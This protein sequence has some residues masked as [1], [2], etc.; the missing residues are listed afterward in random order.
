MAEN[1]FMTLSDEN[2]FMDLPEEK[3]LKSEQVQMKYMPTY[4]TAG[5]KDYA[6]I[7]GGVGETALNLA[8]NLVS[9]AI[10]GPT[11]LNAGALQT[12]AN[13]VNPEFYRQ[14][15]QAQEDFLEGRIDLSQLTPDA[16]VNTAA[17]AS[18]AVTE[19][20]R[21]IFHPRTQGGEIME[22]TL[23]QSVE[24]IGEAIKYPLSAIPWAIAGSEEATKF[25]EV[26]MGT[27]L[28]ELAQDSGASPIWATLAHMTPDIVL[29][30]ASVKGGQALAKGK[31]RIPTRE[32]IKLDYKLLRETIDSSGIRVKGVVVDDA[33]NRIETMLRVEG[34][35]PSLAPKTH[36]ALRDIRNDWA[37]QLK[38]DF[39]IS[40]AE[41]VR[42]TLGNARK[43]IE[44][45][46][47]A[48]A[49]RAVEIMD[50]LLETLNKNKLTVPGN[51]PAKEAAEY[52]KA[53]RE[54]WARNRKTEVIEE[55]FDRA[56]TSGQA[57]VSRT[58]LS[59]NLRREFLNLYRNRRRRLRGFTTEEIEF[60]RRVATGTTI[61]RAARA[62]GTFN[63]RGLMVGSD[64]ATGAAIA[65]MTGDP[66]LG[67]AATGFLAGGGKAGRVLS[68]RLTTRYAD[69][70]L[71]KVRLGANPPSQR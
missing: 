11:G 38:G 41:I 19:T 14:S 46:D 36:G 44:G 65:Y 28:G 64:F 39:S 24:K 5:P 18:Q 2:P 3:R 32:E 16:P 31:P 35:P 29:A 22:E 53:S 34:F 52:I 12:Q 57:Q 66:M 13:A 40:E 1:P 70:A 21:K 20:G 71:N 10:A 23:A 48:A 47:V 43:A 67:M 69:E 61:E 50:N 26:P 59:H 9:R 15:G 62:L 4:F 17:A 7:A 25:R 45:S 8:G 33:L 60:V 6:K 68:N 42:R 49:P 63:P 58:A 55:A 54:L 37:A 51:I 56:R 30:T 27:Y